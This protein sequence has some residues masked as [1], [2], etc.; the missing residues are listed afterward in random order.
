MWEAGTQSSWGSLKSTKPLKRIEQSNLGSY[1]QE[2]KWIYPKIV[3]SSSF[4]LPWE[5]KVL[6]CPSRCQQFESAPRHLDALEVG[7]NDLWTTCH[8]LLIVNMFTTQNGRS[9]G[10]CVP[11]HIPEHTGGS[12]WVKGH[13]NNIRGS[14]WWVGPLFLLF[15]T[16]EHTW[17]SWHHQWQYKPFLQ[18]TSSAW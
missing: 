7:G 4:L 9:S 17:T 3:H 1:W 6:P 13:V 10:T 15:S 11:R 18:T 5:A 8:N 16:H 12:V 2:V 14:V